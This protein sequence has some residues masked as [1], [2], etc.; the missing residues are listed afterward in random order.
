MKKLA[1]AWKPATTLKTGAKT[2]QQRAGFSVKPLYTAFFIGAMCFGLTA[3]RQKAA[4]TDAEQTAADTTA[5][6]APAAT[7]ETPKTAENP[8]VEQTSGNQ[9]NQILYSP[10]A[11]EMKAEQRSVFEYFSK[12][13]IEVTF[14]GGKSSTWVFLVSNNNNFS[15]KVVI[16]YYTEDGKSGTVETVLKPKEKE[17]EV[18][19]KVG[20]DNPVSPWTVKEILKVK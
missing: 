17:K 16:L 1:T 20:I 12:S 10:S 18:D 9:K 6:A 11:D 5:M 8:T 13:G 2:R 14:D 19:P 7:A 3:C 15:C 4:Q